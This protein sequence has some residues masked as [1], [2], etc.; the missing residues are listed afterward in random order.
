MTS[1]EVHGSQPSKNSMLQSESISRPH[2]PSPLN[3]SAALKCQVDD[4]GTTTVTNGETHLKALEAGMGNDEKSDVIVGWDGPD[5]PMN[6]KK[7][8]ISS[9]SQRLHFMSALQLVK[10]EEMGCNHCSFILHVHFSDCIF[11]DGA[12][13]GENLSGIPHHELCRSI[14]DRFHLYFSLR[15]AIDTVCPM[16]R[17]VKV[18]HG[19]RMQHLDRSSGDP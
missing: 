18:S 10:N 19:L 13:S 16:L 2:S 9:V 3:N 7:L 15:Y 11:H 5:D 6:P 17:L 1:H 14:N 12:C 4:D 8:V